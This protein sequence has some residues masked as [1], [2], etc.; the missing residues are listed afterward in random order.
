MAYTFG[1][2]AFGLQT[3]DGMVALPEKKAN[4]NVEHI[5]YSDDD[6]MDIGGLSVPSFKGPIIV[7]AA[8]RAAFEA[9]L[10]EERTLVW[11]SF[12]TTTALLSELS[13]PHMNYDGT[14]FFYN[15]TWIQTV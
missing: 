13:N 6:V 7:L 15:A 1:G 8:N 10:G 11:G 12:A 2:V 14:H 3:S 5:P 4:V 9:L